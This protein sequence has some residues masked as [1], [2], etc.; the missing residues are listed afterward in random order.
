MFVLFFAL[1]HF[2]QMITKFVLTSQPYDNK[3]SGRI[4]HVVINIETHV[5]LFSECSEKKKL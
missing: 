1:L 3:E 4:F 5:F 2:E